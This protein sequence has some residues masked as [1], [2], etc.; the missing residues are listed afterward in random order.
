MSGCLPAACADD[1]RSRSWQCWRDRAILELWRYPPQGLG[2]AVGR[3][4]K[5][6]LTGI[7][8]GLRLLHVPTPWRSD[9][10]C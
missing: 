7:M 5:S 10:P 6:T 8:S 4:S 3:D 1:H 2:T 9:P